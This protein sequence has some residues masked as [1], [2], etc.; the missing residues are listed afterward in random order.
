MRVNWPIGQYVHDT[1]QWNISGGFYD[2]ST[3]ECQLSITKAD[4]SGWYEYTELAL[5]LNL[6]WSNG[7]TEYYQI[8]SGT[9]YNDMSG[10]I[11][12]AS[13]GAVECW[14]SMYC[15]MHDDGAGS[16]GNDWEISPGP[17]PAADDKPGWE[18]PNTRSTL[19]TVPAI[20][21]LRN[22]SPYNENTGVSSSMYDINL[23]WD[24]DDGSAATQGYY[25]INNG[26][27]VQ[28]GTANN[29]YTTCS[30]HQLTP[31]TSYNIRVKNS[32]EAGD[33]NILSITVRTRHR[34]P[35]IT[36]TNITA[37]LE[38]LTVSW[39][40]DKSLRTL[41]YQLNGTSES[42]ITTGDT[43]TSGSFKI[44]GLDYNTE[45]TIYLRGTSTSTYD[46]LT[47]S[48]INESEE[49]L[50]ISHIT[51]IS[52][53]IFGTS[54]TVTISG[55]SNNT[56]SLR[57]WTTGN[58]RTAEVTVRPQ[59]GSNTITLTQDQLDNVY[60]TF[61]RANTMT[62]YFQ[63]ST[64]GSETYTDTRLNRTL[65]LT[66]IARTAHIGVSN[67]SRRSDVYIGVGNKPRRCVSWVGVNGTARRCI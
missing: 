49:T 67:R 2:T 63:L 11:H 5:F 32:N 26:G 58:G 8:F 46:S 60:R 17:G 21:N 29:G 65:T 13:N 61:P 57:I 24:H 53:L 22:D 42:W 59:K 10:T 64:V 7:N 23:R 43:G 54:F 37:E 62:M 18:I 35:V 55:E 25:S 9:G 27:W 40:S 56:M 28:A 34:A 1:P 48:A 51:N 50:D 19:T 47:S 3:G 15:S 39:S 38:A 20:S 30:I 44:S 16:C 52:T 14:I 4:N 6:R 66:G 31:G 12:Q 36:I 41:Q 45:Y 33:S